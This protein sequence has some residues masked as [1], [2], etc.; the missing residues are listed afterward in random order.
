MSRRGPAGT[1]TGG[2]N[3]INIQAMVEERARSLGTGLAIGD[4]GSMRS[5][6]R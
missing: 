5:E 1:A 2:P 4:T 6:R 3:G